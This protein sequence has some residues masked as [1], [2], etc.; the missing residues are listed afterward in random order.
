MYQMVILFVLF[1]FTNVRFLL[2]ISK[3]LIELLMRVGFSFSPYKTVSQ[4]KE[5]NS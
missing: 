3:V 1:F 5:I 2:L 4:R